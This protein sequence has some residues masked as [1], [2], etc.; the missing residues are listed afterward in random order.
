MAAHD[1]RPKLRDQEE[2]SITLEASMIVP[3]VFFLT[4][5]VILFAIWMLDRSLAYYT[6]LAESGRAA[7]A[8]SHSS[9]DLKTGAYPD[10]AYD[11][12]Y[13]RLADDAALAGLFGWGRGSGG[14]IR[15]DV[16]SH[17][18]ADA[19]LAESKLLNTAARLA[20][21]PQ[22]AVTYRN[23]LWKKSLTV[24]G[25]ESRLPFSMPGLR[26]SGANFGA[27]ALV[28]EPAE[29]VRSFELIRYYRNKFETQ[30]EGSESYR[31]KASD[32]L[33]GRA[34]NGQRS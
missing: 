24:E 22:G 17:Q 1:P 15:V 10:G 18:T 28:T 12:L 19:S 21:W 20:K 7:F 23:Q 30:G 34:E 16:G 14:E 6:A 5:A 9:A 32:I 13:W 31:K 25:S 29:W 3:V 8:W 27:A 2:G 4:L 11:G 26:R 33:K